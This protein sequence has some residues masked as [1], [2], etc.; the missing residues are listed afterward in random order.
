M[1]HRQQ[2]LVTTNANTYGINHQTPK[3]T[4]I[5]TNM[6][7]TNRDNNNR[8]SRDIRTSHD[9]YNDNIIHMH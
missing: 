4:N 6:V 7:I 8:N 5:N 2:C 9:I 1:H 3:D